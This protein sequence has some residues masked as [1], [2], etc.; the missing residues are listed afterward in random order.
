LKGAIAFAMRVV[1]VTLRPLLRDIITAL[2]QTRVPVTIVAEF[3]KRAPTERLKLL[4]PDLVVVGLRAGENDRIGQRYLA[5]VPAAT[6]T[7]ISSDGLEA[8]IYKAPGRRIVLHSVS[9]DALDNA[10]ADSDRGN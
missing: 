6:V 1:V 9:H 4:A 7:V 8:Y 5:E 2:L 10:L 3:S